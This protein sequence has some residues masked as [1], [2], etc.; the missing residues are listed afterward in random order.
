MTRVLSHLWVQTEMPSGKE[1]CAWSVFIGLTNRFVKKNARLFFSVSLDRRICL[2]IDGTV[3][4]I[5]GGA[6]LCIN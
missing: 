3:L 4:K 5:E 1:E 2:K 6:T